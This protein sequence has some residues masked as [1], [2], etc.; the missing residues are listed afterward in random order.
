MKPVGTRNFG[1]LF[2]ESTNTGLQHYMY[3]GK[4][5]DRMYGLDWHDYGARHYDAARIQWTTMDPLCEKDY[6]ISPYVYCNDNCVSKLDPDGRRAKVAIRDNNITISTTIITVGPNANYKL[7]Q[8]L[9]KSIYDSWGKIKEFTYKGRKYNIKWDIQ[10]KTNAK[11]PSM[12]SAKREDSNYNYLQIDKKETSGVSAT[13]IGHIR[14]EARNGGDFDQDNP[15]PHEF[16][17][18]L[19]HPDKYDSKNNPISPDWE[20]NVMA[21]LAG[22]GS[23]SEKNINEILSPIM[24]KHLQYIESSAFNRIIIF[25]WS[26]E[27][28]ID[29]NPSEK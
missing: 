6:S 15:M 19:G 29:Y 14:S 25:F 12:E 11:I 2:A 20:G 3:T 22:Q 18:I 13:R 10:V 17:H 9:Q 21:E 24:E 26:E 4:E 1:G 28:I 7:S 27:Y 8:K 5:L 16:G 23:P